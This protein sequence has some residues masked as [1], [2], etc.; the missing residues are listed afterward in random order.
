M[1]LIYEIAADLNIEVNRNLTVVFTGCQA[2]RSRLVS[3]C[4]T[5]PCNPERMDY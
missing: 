1:N 5:A 4:E 2:T 3:R